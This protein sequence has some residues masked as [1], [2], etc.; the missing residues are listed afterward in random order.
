LPCFNPATVHHASRC[1]GL[2]VKRSRTFH[3]VIFYTHCICLKKIWRWCF[4]TGT[5]MVHKTGKKNVSR[6][7]TQ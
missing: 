6:S 5:C 4:Y 1:K 7:G 2:Q 3:V